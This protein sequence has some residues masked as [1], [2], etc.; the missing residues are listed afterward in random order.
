[1]Q[2]IRG[3]LCLVAVFVAGVVAVVGIF[4]FFFLCA[5]A[6]LLVCSAAIVTF[7]GA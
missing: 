3:K 7:G 2:Y 4:T 1:M 6:Q 5:R